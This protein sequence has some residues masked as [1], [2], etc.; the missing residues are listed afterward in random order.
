MKSCAAS[1]AA[2]GG[3]TS[4]AVSGGLVGDVSCPPMVAVS[5]R[6]FTSAS[7][8]LSPWSD[9]QPPFTRRRN[10]TS[11]VIEVEERIVASLKF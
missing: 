7:W 4:G 3:L 6:L 2:S 1:A 5:G 8:P 11:M 9:P 10:P